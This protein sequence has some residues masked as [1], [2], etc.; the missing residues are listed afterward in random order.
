MSASDYFLKIEDAFISRGKARLL[1][2]TEWA[3]IEQWEEKGIP[4]EVVL[5]GIERAFD[6]HGEQ[7]RRI[8][9]LAYCAPHIER[10]FAG[11][12]KG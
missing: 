7:R 6:S 5:R 8:N 11:I 3:L 9:S 4:V 1:S 2:P 12:V 10:E